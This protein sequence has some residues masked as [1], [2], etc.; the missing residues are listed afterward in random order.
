MFRSSTARARNSRVVI[1]SISA[2]CAAGA[3]AA[4]ASIVNGVW[5][6]AASAT[7]P[8]AKSRVLG[9]D[10]EWMQSV[11]SGRYFREQTEGAQQTAPRQR[12]NRSPRGGS[13][14]RLYSSPK[15]PRPSPEQRI[16]SG[17]Y[18]TMCVRL[19]D[20]Y[21][22]PVSFATT[23]GNFARDQKVCEKSCSSPAKLYTYPNPGGE[24][25][26]M[27]DI[28]GQPY[29][30][31]PTAYFY[32]AI[33]DENCKCRAHPWEQQSL[34]RHRRYAL[35]ARARKGDKQA[36]RELRSLKKDAKPA[37]RRSRRGSRRRR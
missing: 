31:L 29:S 18:R 15:D 16:G 32:Q 26:E 24:I 7:D 30:G 25:E 17:T 9:S 23:P 4:L 33:Y 36:R 6:F 27:A 12:S 19:C 21:A 10:D 34:E 28:K 11:R 8:A 35:E 2:V 20:G 3:L 22:W 14:P 1:A 13:S 37:P 5:P